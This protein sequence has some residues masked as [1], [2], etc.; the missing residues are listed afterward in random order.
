MHFTVAVL[1]KSIDGFEDLL[2]PFQENNME[3]CPEEYLEFVNV[4]EKC[5]KEYLEEKTEGVIM[6]DGR[7]LSQWDREFDIVLP[8]GKPFSEFEYDYSKLPKGQSVSKKIPEELE[9][10]NVSF[11]EIYPTFDDFMKDYHGYT[12]RDSKTNSYGYWMN[13]NAKWDWY[14][15]GGRWRGMLLVKNSVTSLLGSPGVFGD[16]YNERF[17]P[18]GYRWVDSAQLKD[19]EWDMMADINKKKA[20]EDWKEIHEKL[21]SGEFDSAYVSIVYDI[22]KNDTMDSYVEKCA[23]FGTYAILTNDGSWYDSNNDEFKDNYFE[24]YVKNADKELYLSIID[25][26]I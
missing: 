18:K 17:T 25:C 16:D 11:Q 9:V 10:R 26:H 15:L 7:V 4:E 8:L 6:P 23:K 13:P 24:K 14:Q 12:E 20:E 2:T 19:I 3:D 21:E 5:L 1:S 22:G